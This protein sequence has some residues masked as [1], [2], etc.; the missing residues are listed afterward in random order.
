VLAIPSPHQEWKNSYREYHAHKFVEEKIKALGN[1]RDEVCAKG[2]THLVFLLAAFTD[3]VNPLPHMGNIAAK[4]M[5]FPLF[6]GGDLEDFSVSPTENVQ[7]KIFSV[8]MPQIAQAIKCLSSIGATHTDV[9]KNN[10]FLSKDKNTAFLGDFGQM[11]YIG[12]RFPY[13]QKLM[14]RIASPFQT[15]SGHFMAG[16]QRTNI[17]GPPAR[18]TTLPMCVV[19]MWGWAVTA[20]EFVTNGLYNPSMFTAV[21]A[22]KQ[23]IALTAGKIQLKSLWKRS[24][25][26]SRQRWCHPVG[27][28]CHAFTW[29]NKLLEK[30]MHG[31]PPQ[32]IQSEIWQ[33][34]LMRVNPKKARTRC[35]TM[36]QAKYFLQVECDADQD[37]GPPK[38]DPQSKDTPNH[39]VVD[40]TENGEEYVPYSAP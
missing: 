18:Y 30:F 10:I 39:D 15:L 38:D 20:L 16:I 27:T 35:L 34:P 1:G 25:V 7:E 6:G 21:E 23:I 9:H 3:P 19:D 4:L 17:N 29:A 36:E 24:S 22:Q 11:S 2:K 26:V 14:L 32:N 31:Q 12:M 37:P 5:V 40:E 33:P 8:F 28:K 13:V